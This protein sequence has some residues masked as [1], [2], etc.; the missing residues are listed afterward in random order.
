LAYDN[1]AVK[2]EY[3]NLR[4]ARIDQQINCSLLDPTLK[5]S[6]SQG[7]IETKIDDD[8]EGYDDGNILRNGQVWRQIAYKCNNLRKI[9]HTM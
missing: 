9:T 7:S 1:L 3:K 4:T 6:P 2:N 5:T 8:F